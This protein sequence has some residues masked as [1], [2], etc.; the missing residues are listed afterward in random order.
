MATKK[1]FVLRLDHELYDALMHWATDEFRSVN[2]H[3]EWMLAE[4]CK[5]RGRGHKQECRTCRLRLQK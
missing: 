4:S 5:R 2:S 3:I 1:S